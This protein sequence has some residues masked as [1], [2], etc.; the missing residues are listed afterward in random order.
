[1]R[2]LIEGEQYPIELL[3]ELL[4]HQHFYITKKD[5]GIIN[6]VGYLHDLVHGEVI[7]LLPKVFYWNRLIFGKYTLESL[8][9]F[10]VELSAKHDKQYIWVRQ[11]LVVFYKS[12]TEFKRRHQDTVIVE[13]IQSLELNSNLGNQEYTY[14]DLMLSFL[15]FYK[16]N[17]NH[18]QYRHIEQTTQHI[19]H[20]KWAKTIRKTIPLMKHRQEPIYTNVKNRKKVK[21][22]E[23]ELLTIFFSILNHFKT[24]HD[25]TITIN[26]I[27]SIY[28]GKKFEWLQ[29]NGLKVLRRIKYK[30]FSDQL[31]RT[32]Q[33]CELYLSKTDQ[34]NVKRKQ[35]E[36]IA[37][38]NYN[39]V[40]EDMV[41]KLFTDEQ[42]QKIQQLKNNRD[43][44]I[45]D[46][47]YKYQSLIDDSHVFY[48]GDSK[49]YKSDNTASKT[50]VYKQFTY[51]KNVIQFNIDLF[52][53]GKSL[54]RL[55]YRDEL[56]EGYNIS[57][58]FF[59][60]GYLPTSENGEMITDFEGDFLQKNDEK[61]HQSYHFKERLFDR[62]TLFV[63]PY[64]LNFLFVLNAYTLR[65]QSSIQKFRDN[66]KQVFR[67]NFIDFFNNAEECRFQFYVK[68]F[69]EEEL[70]AF[71][72]L[73]FKAL[74]G[75]MITLSK[76]QLL[77]A[78][79]S[80]DKSS[81]NL[82]ESFETFQL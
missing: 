4:G 72:N 36:F 55:R 81:F 33:L 34:S 11:L 40:F 42:G 68:T 57:P 3:E 13:P 75:K 44:K 29:N 31:R 56:T 46:H 52:H 43:G 78:I 51:A 27:Y 8:S 74:N 49:Y 67:Q 26:P 73:N 22:N 19:K 16:K 17:K 63:H 6:Y 1:M 15:N 69:E 12:L 23:E 60:Y 21:N 48:I 5:K 50:S 66:T 61:I 80:N 58:N 30:Y 41:D 38:R 24:S 25:L 64:Q 28:K 70:T 59:I 7:Y 82:L 18:I 2:I 10:P 47:L 77:I 62:D 32:Y 37:V 71:I 65:N 79:S 35:T 20:P 76:Y 39:I 9:N 53:E 45:I 54:P 14:L